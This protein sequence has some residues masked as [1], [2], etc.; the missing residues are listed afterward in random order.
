MFSALA[1]LVLMQA[2]PAPPRNLTAS[3]VETVVG[4]QLIPDGPNIWRLQH[5]PLYGASCTLN[6][7][8]I[9]P[10]IGK[11]LKVATGTGQYMLIASGIYPFP[12]GSW[13]S[14]LW[15]G[16]DIGGPLDSLVVCDYEYRVDR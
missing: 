3:F 1:L 14:A 6:G 8:V 15:S 4:E 13:P 16:G 7:A 5:A 2:A 9:G 12:Q 11:N 10:M